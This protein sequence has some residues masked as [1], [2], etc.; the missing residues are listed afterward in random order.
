LDSTKIP[1]AVKYLE[2]L[3]VAGLASSVHNE[4]LRTCY[5]KLGDVDAAS[6][7]ILEGSSSRDVPALNPDGTEVPTVSISRNLLACAD[8]PSE[9]LAAICSLHPPEAVKA[10]VAHGVLIARSLPRETAGV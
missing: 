1:L 10:L 8:N 3:R 4:L 2:A 6:R 5:L 9:M 7:I